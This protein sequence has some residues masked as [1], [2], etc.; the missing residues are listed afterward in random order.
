MNIY[1][2]EIDIYAVTSCRG[3]PIKQQRHATIKDI[4]TRSAVPSQ[5]ELRRKL[6]RRGHKVTQATL[7]RDV[8]E[9]NLS[10]GPAG[11]SIGT[12]RESGTPGIQEILNR[13]A[14]E[15]RQAANLLVLITASG[16]AQPVAAGVDRERWAALLGTIAGDDT[17]LLICRDEAAAN[18]LR[19]QI[20][21]SLAS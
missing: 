11:Y 6:A 12:V 2:V 15:V 9:L 10:K 4:L 8:H 7:S 13:F 20:G 14:I 1:T 3:K 19:Q 5:D 18:A 17:V 21:A 16:S